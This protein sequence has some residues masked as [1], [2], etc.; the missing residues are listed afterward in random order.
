[1]TKAQ[2]FIDAHNLNFNTIDLESQLPVYLQEMRSGLLGEPSS[3]LMLPTYLHL[4]EQVSLNEPIICVDA[5]G[6]N[7]RIAKA[8]FDD[9]GK[10]NIL[11]IE[12]YLMPGVEKELESQEFFDIMASYI[13]PFCTDTKRIVL[14]FAY[15]AKTTSNI[16]CEIIEITKE[17][18]V[19]NA[20]G[21]LLGKEIISSLNSIGIADAEIIVINDSVATALSGKAE[22]LTEGFSTFT[23]TILGTGSNSCY[24]EDNA[25]IKKVSGLGQGTMVINTEA[26]SYNKM[27]RS[28]IDMAFDAMLQNPGIGISEKMSS[29]A[30]LG[31]LCAQV[32]ECAYLEQVFDCIDLGN[33]N[34]LT[35]EDVSKFL[36][37]E[38]G[39]LANLE[40]ST[41]DKDSMV[42]ILTNIVKR[43]ARV[44]ALQMAAVAIKAYKTN[45]KVC[46]TIEGSTYEKMFGL[47]EELLSV[48]IPFLKRQGIEAKVVE[49]DLAVLKG[50]AI[51]GLSM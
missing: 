14:S 13:K 21:K 46:M 1:M 8:I 2:K 12:R 26:G 30:Y 22:H 15:R 49:L 45:P 32:I 39:I 16:D 43:T 33:L 50:C 38:G 27:P 24:I 37:G 10:F 40:L 44:V 51:A 34:E 29:G 28:D 7:L 17:V 48:L 5:G 4:K 3:L 20:G 18:K 6:T 35:S 25:N 31:A 42:E 36:A 23:G 41:Q 9:N 47:K 11:K 19:K